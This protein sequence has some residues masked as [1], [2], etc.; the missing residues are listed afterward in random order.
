MC[1]DGQAAVIVRGN[2][3]ELVGESSVAGDRLPV[4]RI[5]QPA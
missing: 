1:P 2:E 3:V 5:R 4:Y